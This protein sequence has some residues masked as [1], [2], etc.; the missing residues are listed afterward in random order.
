MVSFFNFF[1]LVKVSEAYGSDDLRVECLHDKR[2]K[3]IKGESLFLNLYDYW[4]LLHAELKFHWYHPKIAILEKQI[5]KNLRDSKELLLA[6]V[7]VKKF[8]D[9]EPLFSP[10]NYLDDDEKYLQTMEKW[11]NDFQN[12]YLEKYPHLGLKDWPVRHKKIYRHTKRLVF[13]KINFTTF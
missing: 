1:S 12:E 8:K 13:F 11:K 2:G 9:K 10:V 5:R 3:N 7:F 4:T 6:N